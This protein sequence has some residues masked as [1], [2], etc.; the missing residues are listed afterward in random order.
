MD[1]AKV[2]EKFQVFHEENPAVYRELVKISR[3]L[4]NR[5]RDHYGMRALFEVIRFHR[6]MNT[7]DPDYKLNN[8]YTPHYARLIMDQ[9][10]D[11]EG[12][13][14]LRSLKE[15][16]TSAWEDFYDQAMRETELENA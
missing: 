4:K 1:E 10:K 6:A 11:L 15:P 2:K 13:F 5:G 9:E 8:N 3:E 14:D 12:F 16:D 7:N